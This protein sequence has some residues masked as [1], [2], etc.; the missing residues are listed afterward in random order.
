MSLGALGKSSS[1]RIRGPL[2]DSKT[3]AKISKTLQVFQICAF[4]LLTFFIV[5]MNVV[6]C[7]QY[8]ENLELLFW[9]STNVI[10]KIGR[11]Y[12]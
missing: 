12:I 3:K 1:G 9:L 10:L 8:I 4:S 5:V 7:N 6:F 11:T 2:M